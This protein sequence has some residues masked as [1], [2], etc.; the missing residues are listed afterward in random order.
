MLSHVY[1]MGDKDVLI[2]GIRHVYMVREVIGDMDEYK[3][4]SDA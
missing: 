3:S 2:Y 1:M 4:A